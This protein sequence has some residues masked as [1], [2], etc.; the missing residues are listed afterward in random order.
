MVLIYVKA[1]STPRPWCCWKVQ[2]DLKK[3][4]VISLGIDRLCGLM[5]L[6]T[7]PEVRVLVP[8]LPDFLRSSGPGTGST[9]PREYSY[10]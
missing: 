10:N 6:A 8:A 7:D 4:P 9:Q 3:N 5:F 1:E 2:G